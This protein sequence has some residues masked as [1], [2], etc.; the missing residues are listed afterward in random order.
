MTRPISRQMTSKRIIM[1]IVTSWAL[2]VFGSCVRF[3]LKRIFQAV[4]ILFNFATCIGL[5]IFYSLIVKSLRR[6][7]IEAATAESE[8][9]PSSSVNEATKPST[10]SQK[11]R[12]VEKKVTKKV[13]VLIFAY[14]IT[15]AP[16]TVLAIP[17]LVGKEINQLARFICAYLLM[18][19]SCINPIIYIAGDR[20]F[21]KKFFAM[22]MI[23]SKISASSTLQSSSSSS[24]Q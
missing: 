21:R 18:L 19:N 7:R 15:F 10:M 3:Y 17:L 11:K 9:Q 1:A 4:L 23:K 16:I 12:L 22:F 20:R 14:Y 2:T 24:S 8:N 13:L 5:V 6:A